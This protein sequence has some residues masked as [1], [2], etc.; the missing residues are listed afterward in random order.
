MVE[1]APK[2][3]PF[4]RKPVEAD[5]TG[6]SWIPSDDQS[7]WAL[8]FSHKIDP[9]LQFIDVTGETGI[10]FRP[11]RF[12]SFTGGGSLPFIAEE[13]SKLPRAFLNHQ[14]QILPEYENMGKTNDI[15]PTHVTTTVQIG[16]KP[17]ESKYII[18]GLGD[19]DATPDENTKLIDIEITKDDN[20]VVT[21]RD[22]QRNNEGKMV[23]KTA[24]NGGKYPA[25]AEVFT[26]I[27]QRLA[28][29]KYPK[30]KI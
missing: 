10:W 26:R 11:I 12:R 13:L 6:I 14:G 4:E 9:H 20:A 27:A 17:D 15:F 29:A 1:K 5:A 23:F 3:K 8:N 22:T 25:V 21:M 7:P 19:D 28:K 2:D 24:K 18:K 16:K 30:L